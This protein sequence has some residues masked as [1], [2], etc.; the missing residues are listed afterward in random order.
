MRKNNRKEKDILKNKHERDMGAVP[1]EIPFAVDEDLIKEIVEEPVSEEAVPF[2]V[3]EEMINEPGDEVSEEEIPFAVDEDIISQEGESVPEEIPFAVNEEEIPDEIENTG[4]L[5]QDGDEGEKMG[6]RKHQRKKTK[7]SKKKKVTIIITVIISVIAVL[8]LG[9]F[10]AW[11]WVRHTAKKLGDETHYTND[12]IEDQTTKLHFKNVEDIKGNIN[13]LILG[14]DKDGTRSDSI[15]LMSYNTDNN[16]IKLLS[17]PR[18]TRIYVEDRKMTRK[19]TEVH[20]MHDK[21][22]NIYGAGAVMQ[23]VKNLTG[24]EINYYV[25][26]S[27]EALDGIMNE[28]GPVKFDVPDLEGK[29]RGMN[30]DDPY[31]DLH[32]HLK[33]GMQELSGN[34]IQQFLRYRKSNYKDAQNV[35]GSDLQRVERQQELLG[36]IIDQKLN[37]G[38]ITKVPG[39]LDAVKKNLRTTF[40]GDE[41]LMYMDFLM[42]NERFKNISSENMKSFVLPGTDRMVNGISYFISDEDETAEL[43]REEFGVE[44]VKAENLSSSIVLGEKKGS[45][46]VTTTTSSENKDKGSTKT[47]KKKTSGNTDEDSYDEERTETRK[48][49][50]NPK[51]D[52]EEFEEMKKEDEKKKSSSKPKDSEDKSASDEKDSDDKDE[53]K[54]SENDEKDGEDK[55]ASDEKDSQPKSEKSDSSNKDGE[56]ES[57]G[58]TSSD[59]EKNSTETSDDKKTSTEKTDEKTSGGTEKTDSSTTEKPSGGSNTSTD[60][61]AEKPSGESNTPAEKPA[62]STNTSSEKAA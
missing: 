19:I 41:I 44:D 47:D 10:G 43:I 39:I 15:M 55:S 36:A 2:E 33:P 34:Q 35:N 37:I 61:P 62:D 4:D 49:Q 21:S 28:L 42:L 45:G 12:G 5:G 24:L 26:F 51:S 27:F 8:V 18:D 57:S 17:I 59:G 52:E 16:E 25:E 31:Q 38:V 6:K 22:G 58:K 14:V 48:N 3:E 30:Y 32:I 9:V 40:T 54:S 23:A 1:E 29:G 50:K 60:K 53:E 13:I 11:Q 56:K 20:A 46:K 7:M